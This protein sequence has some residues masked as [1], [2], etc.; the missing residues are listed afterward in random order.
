M[1]EQLGKLVRV[2]P[3]DV[4][5]NEATDFTPWLRD[6]IDCLA[7]AVGIDIDLVE[8]EVAV[9]N[10]SVDLVGE[11]PGQNRPV[12]IENQLER[13]NHTHL[14]QLLTYAA[15][16]DGGV[17]IWV[18][19]EIRPEHRSALEWLNDAT[20][21]NLDFFGVE[22]EVLQIEGSTLKAPNFKV[23]VTPK[24]YLTKT[25]PTPSRSLTTGALSERGRRYQTYFQALLGKIKEREPGVPRKRRIG[26]HGWV[27]LEPSGVGFKFVAA[28]A[29]GRRFRVEVYIDK[30]NQVSNKRVFGLLKAYKEEIENQIGTELAWER[31]DT[32]RASRIAWYYGQSVTIMDSKETLEELEEWTV[33]SFFKF[34]KEMS[35][36]IQNVRIDHV[37]DGLDGPDESFDEEE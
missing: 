31:L 4:W 15:G 21:G 35:P 17:I 33:E 26:F 2:S 22:L 5:A 3:R 18:S 7:E 1:A 11:E 8:S 34:R 10:F 24:E 25:A 36:C 14:G 30:G 16:R 29:S 37:G 6:N 13:T 12:I 28:F 19:P 32:R 23:V 27:D 9:G 20:R